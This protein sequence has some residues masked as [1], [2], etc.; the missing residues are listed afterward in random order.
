MKEPGIPK[1][2]EDEK[3]WK[4]QKTQKRRPSFVNRTD[5]SREGLVRGADPI[6]SA[7]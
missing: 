4:T 7:P 5:A 1:D 3:T 6:G 2:E